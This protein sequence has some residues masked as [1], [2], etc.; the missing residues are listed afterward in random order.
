MFTRI[1]SQ[2]KG[3]VKASF[4]IAEE[5]AG[6]CKPFTEGEFIKNCIEKVCDVVCPDKKQAFADISLSRNTVASRVD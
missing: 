2:S 4:I 6:V 3:A 5:I 1:N